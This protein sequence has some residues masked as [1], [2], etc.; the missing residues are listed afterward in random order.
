MGELVRSDGFLAVGVRQCAKSCG[1]FTSLNKKRIKFPACR[2]KRASFFLFTFALAY[3]MKAE[4][5]GR[6]LARSRKASRSSPY[7]VPRRPYPRSSL[8]TAP[9]PVMPPPG[10]PSYKAAHTVLKAKK[11][12]R[13]SIG[14]KRYTPYSMTRPDHPPT[15][16]HSADDVIV[17]EITFPEPIVYGCHFQGVN[18]SSGFSIPASLTEDQIQAKPLNDSHFQV[19][20][21]KIAQSNSAC[22]TKIL[23][24]GIS[25]H[26]YGLQVDEQTCRQLKTLL[27]GEKSMPFCLAWKVLCQID[28]RDLCYNKAA[29]RFEDVFPSTPALPPFEEAWKIIGQMTYSDLYKRQMA[30]S[31][32]VSVPKEPASDGPNDSLNKTNHNDVLPIEL[33]ASMALVPGTLNS[34][35]T[36]SKGIYHSGSRQI[37]SNDNLQFGSQALTSTTPE[38]QGFHH[39]IYYR[40]SPRNHFPP[41]YAQFEHDIPRQEPQCMDVVCNNFFLTGKVL[42]RQIEHSLNFD[43]PT[44]PPEIMVPFPGDEANRILV[45]FEQLSRVLIPWLYLI[46]SCIYGVLSHVGKLSAPCNLILCAFIGAYTASTRY[47]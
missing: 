2:Y 10:L 21:Q 8:F 19:K 29:I 42:P 39:R 12:S 38:T 11:V 33:E 6:I 31:P 24:H 15:R 4:R 16:L 37:N 43:M 35:I 47:A 18:H 28:S 41:P 1:C 13:K 46:C 5:R 40:P 22:N 45:T 25:V 32:K 44:P 30:Q 17:P 34:P 27:Q 23:K 36:E 9:E 7:H 3:D 20:A 14:G 26:H